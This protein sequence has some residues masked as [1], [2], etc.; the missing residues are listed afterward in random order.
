MKKEKEAEKALKDALIDNSPAGDGVVSSDN[1]TP[2][3]EPAV[4]EPSAGQVQAAVPADPTVTALQ[5]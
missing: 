2:A 1:L 4:L 5:V 3:D